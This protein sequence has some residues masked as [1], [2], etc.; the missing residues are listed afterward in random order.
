MATIA[1]ITS[2]L[3]Y[4]GWDGFGLSDEAWLVI[5]LAVALVVAALAA[6]MRRDTAYLL[7]LVWAFAG[8]HGHLPASLWLQPAAWTATAIVVLLAAASLVWRR[9]Q[10]IRRRHQRY[11][12]VEP[13]EY[14]MSAPSEG[15]SAGWWNNPCWNRRDLAPSPIRGR[16]AC[17]AI[18]MLRRNRLAAAAKASVWF[19]ATRLGHHRVPV[20]RC[21]RPWATRRCGRPSPPSAS[22]RCTPGR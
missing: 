9:P 17:G 21:W 14:T 2:V 4:V 5:M 11:K 1:N 7:V 3:D 15:Q 16:D 8:D 22:R 10:R 19:S 12:S 6:W 13:K 18:P 20:I